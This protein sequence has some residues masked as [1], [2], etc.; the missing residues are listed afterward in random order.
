MRGKEIVMVES[1]H[2][3]KTTFYAVGTTDRTKYCIFTG[4][5]E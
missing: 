1:N 3:A 4:K 5:I 2:E